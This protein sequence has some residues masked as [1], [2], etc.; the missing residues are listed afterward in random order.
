MASQNGKIIATDDGL[1]PE[2]D[3]LKKVAYKGKWVLFIRIIW[4]LEE[5]WIEAG[6]EKSKS[7]KEP[8]KVFG[9][10]EF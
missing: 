8:R 6:G 3:L 9:L 2:N 7:G 10:E 5:S 4:I 1:I